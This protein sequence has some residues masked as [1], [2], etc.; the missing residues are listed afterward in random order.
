MSD[1]GAWIGICFVG[2]NILLFASAIGIAI[3]GSIALWYY[4]ARFHWNA[5]TFIRT[6]AGVDRSTPVVL[7][8]L[9]LRSVSRSSRHWPAKLGYRLLGAMTIERQEVLEQELEAWSFTARAIAGRAP[10]K[11]QLVG[12][13][14]EILPAPWKLY[15]V[16]G[17]AIGTLTVF[18]PSA[19]EW[20]AFSGLA[21]VVG[22]RHYRAP[23]I[24]P[25]VDG[26]RLAFIGAL[27][28]A[29]LS[30]GA[31]SLQRDGLVRLSRDVYISYPERFVCCVWDGKPPR[32]AK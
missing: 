16:L 25:L 17:F 27:V 32:G 13:L 15:V 6:L 18:L 30:V 29:V 8:A 24:P 23:D 10:R 3:F 4:D 9:A 21:F 19:M 28:G 31:H 12:A 26:I 1:W 11:S 14:R 5:A 22:W 2:L 7:L 20:A